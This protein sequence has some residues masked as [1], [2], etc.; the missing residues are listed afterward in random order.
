M[1]QSNKSTN[2]VLHPTL[3][4]YIDDDASIEPYNDHEIAINRFDSLIKQLEACA[5]A[6]DSGWDWAIQQ[7]LND[8]IKAKQLYLVWVDESY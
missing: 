7:S 4:K 5:G 6:Y 8:L 3:A 2:I 1:S